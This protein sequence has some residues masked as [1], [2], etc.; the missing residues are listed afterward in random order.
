MKVFQ[1]TELELIKQNHSHQRTIEGL[2]ARIREME[3]YIALVNQEQEDRT[4][5]GVT[6]VWHV[7][8]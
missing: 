1:E 6:A 4:K 3:E 5:V 7:R 2:V 8:S